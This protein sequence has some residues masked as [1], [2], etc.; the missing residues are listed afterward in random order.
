MLSMNLYNSKGFL[1][2]L[3]NLQSS[4]ICGQSKM[5]RAVRLRRSLIAS[6]CVKLILFESIC[7]MRSVPKLTKYRESGKAGVDEGLEVVALEQKVL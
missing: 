1:K 4:V 5:F 2:F 6:K 3:I 7:G